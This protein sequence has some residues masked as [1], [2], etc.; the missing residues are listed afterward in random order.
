MA[1]TE[2]SNGHLYNTEQYATCPYCNGNGSFNTINFGAAPDAGGIGRTVPVGGFSSNSSKMGDTVAPESY[3]KKQKQEDKTVGV[4]GKRMNLE[5]VTAWLVCIEGTNKGKDYKLWAKNNT[6]GRSEDMDV[7][8]KG[9]MS[10]SRQNHARLSYDEKHN[11][12][13]LI[14]AENTNNIYINDEPVYIPT[15]LSAYDCI[16]FGESK[17]IFVPFCSDKFT[18]KD[19]LIQN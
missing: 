10:I 14:P 7:C 3:R 19:G 16:E 9:D 8:I 18:W 11:N 5:P 13:Y 1:I 4:F 2:C 6:I 12:F 17:M 15:K